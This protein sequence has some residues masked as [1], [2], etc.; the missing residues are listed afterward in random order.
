MKKALLIGINYRGLDGELRGC[1]N[2][3]EQMNKV[4]SE[5]YNYNSIEMLTDDTELKPTKHNIL[6]LLRNLIKESK[7][8]QEIFIHY[9]GHGTYIYDRNSDEKDKKDEALVPIDYT[10]NGL[11]VDDELNQIIANTECTTRIV[12]DCCHSG[13]GLDLYIRTLPLNKT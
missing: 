13:S 11:L 5:Q 3:V 12:L 7:S 2:D 6:N 8:C 1:I 9:S 4:L 10:S